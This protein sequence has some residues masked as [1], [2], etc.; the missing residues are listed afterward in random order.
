MA[1][2]YKKI[3]EIEN[4]SKPVSEEDI[5]RICQLREDSY[6]RR[7]EWAVK[8]KTEWDQSEKS[9]WICTLDIIYDPREVFSVK[10]TGWPYAVGLQRE[11]EVRKWTR[12]KQF[13]VVLL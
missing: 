13:N 1:K 3:Q 5:R 8:L 12:I 11:I 2:K 6:W 10:Q 4:L 9:L 7:K